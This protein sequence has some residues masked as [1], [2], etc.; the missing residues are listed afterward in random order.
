MSI[1]AFLETSP[2]GRSSTQP[3]MCLQKCTRRV[4]TT[5]HLDRRIG[6]GDRN[7]P[8]ADGIKR[9]RDCNR[10]AFLL[11]WNERRRSTGNRYGSL[12]G[13]LHAKRLRDFVTFP[14]QALSRTCEDLVDQPWTE[15]SFTCPIGN[16][17]AL[18]PKLRH[19]FVR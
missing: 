3:V 11:S 17:G 10:A 13:L 1:A 6:S 8:G 18:A 19:R 9:P 4:L 12:Q 7:L 2:D 15:A 14:A 5:P 16:V